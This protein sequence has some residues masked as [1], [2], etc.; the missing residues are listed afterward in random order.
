VLVQIWR[1]DELVATRTS[2][3]MEPLSAQVSLPFEGRL[4]ALH[5]TKGEAAQAL[6]G[7][8]DDPAVVVFLERAAF[9][10]QTPGRIRDR[11]RL[12]ARLDLR[13]VLDRGSWRADS[14]RP[15]GVGARGGVVRGDYI[16]D[17]RERGESRIDVVV[18]RDGSYETLSIDT[19]E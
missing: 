14:V 9:S 10:V 16:V 13:V 12:G 8:P 5:P 1:G 17:A 15:E 3:G 6:D 7:V 2:R 18:W 4:V 19:S 11:A